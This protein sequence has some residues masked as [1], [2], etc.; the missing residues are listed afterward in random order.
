[1]RETDPLEVALVDEPGLLHDALRSTIRGE[2]EADEL[3]EA[4]DVEGDPDELAR[5]LGRE[6]TAPALGHQAV[7]DLDLVATDDLDVPR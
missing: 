6:A 4:E 7:T 1:V 2:G 5:R 3:L